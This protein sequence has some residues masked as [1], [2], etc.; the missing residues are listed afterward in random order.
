MANSLRMYQRKDW[1]R[2]FPGEEAAEHAALVSKPVLLTAKITAAL[3][4]A[5]RE[6]GHL[7]PDHFVI[8][9]IFSAPLPTSCLRP[10]RGYETSLVL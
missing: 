3:S 1:G 10:G 2:P 7:P 5:E 9:L 4:W 8:V 6:C